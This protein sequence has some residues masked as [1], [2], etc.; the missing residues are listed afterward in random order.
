VSL[1]IGRSVTY[2]FEDPDWP[3]KLVVFLIVGFVPGLNLI[4][5]SGYAISVGRN[6]ARGLPPL[7]G[8]EEWSDIAVRG[9]LA[10][11]AAA[12]YSL[13][14][15]IV[16]LLLSWIGA[17]AGESAFLALRCGGIMLAGAYLLLANLLLSVGYVHH[18]R[19][20]QSFHY[21]HVIARLR[22]F[23][24]NPALYGQHFAFQALLAFL[25]FMLTGVALA[26]FL[27]AMSTIIT[28]GGAL[29]LI[30]IGVLT[31]GSLGFV[32]IVTLA[33]LA[34][35]YFLGMAAASQRQFA[36]PDPIRRGL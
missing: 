5:W 20:D 26:L 34:N 21:T 29:A 28:E 10:I 8:W 24:Q 14:A 7:P 27:V 15:L 25:L 30:L 19:T 1:D 16:Y 17:L 2:P 11:G 23:Q 35:G 6:I 9:F 31:L 22:D 13:P 18:A 12:L 4:L 33:F 32:A 36:P 3:R